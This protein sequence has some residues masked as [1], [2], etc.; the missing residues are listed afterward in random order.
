MHERPCQKLLHFHRLLFQQ[1]RVVLLSFSPSAASAS[2]PSSCSPSIPSAT[3]PVP[4]ETPSAFPAAA[5]APP[6]TTAP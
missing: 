6:P 5:R 2:L 4:T 1:L 3:E